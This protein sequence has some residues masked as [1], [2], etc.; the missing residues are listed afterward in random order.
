M[1]DLVRGLNVFG[2]ITD[3]P[4][5]VTLSLGA[6]GT[7]ISSGDSCKSVATFGIDTSLR[8]YIRVTRGAEFWSLDGQLLVPGKT[9]HM[10]HK[11]TVFESR[12]VFNDRVWFR[13]R[14]YLLSDWKLTLLVEEPTAVASRVQLY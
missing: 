13:W 14:S 5:E 9:T 4:G 10:H 6:D 7:E 2:K 11:N 3:V 8:V 12:A 1:M